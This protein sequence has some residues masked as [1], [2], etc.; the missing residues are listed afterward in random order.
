MT[1][2]AYHAIIAVPFGRLGLLE[3]QAAVT[4]IDFLPPG[5]ELLVP[6]TPSLRKVAAALRGWCEDPACALDFACVAQGSAFQKRVWDALCAIPR[7]HT[8]TYGELA[9]RLGSSP[10]AVGQACG[11]NPLPIVIPCH[12]AVGSRGLGGFMHAQSDFPLTLKRWLLAH[13]RRP[14]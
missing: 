2:A 3:Q 4:R 12:R 1:L 11:A 13:E 6:A 7:G 10:R 9:R 14:D 8:E 5:E